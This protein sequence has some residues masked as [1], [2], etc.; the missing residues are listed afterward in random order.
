M[1]SLALF[2]IVAFCLFVTVTARAEEEE[3]KEATETKSESGG[4]EAEKTEK[5]EETEETGEKCEKCETPASPQ[6]AK[7]CPARRG[8]YF[9]GNKR[10]SCVMAAPKRDPFPPP[11]T[12]TAPTRV[13]GVDGKEAQFGGGPLRRYYLVGGGG[14]GMPS[15]TASTGSGMRTLAPGVMLPS[16]TFTVGSGIAIAPYTPRMRSAAPAKKPYYPANKGKYDFK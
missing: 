12:G 11:G 2:L 3:K 16:Q 4:S 6:T 15:H 14:G 9:E 10:K 7:P 8:Y 5:T 13:K 1:R